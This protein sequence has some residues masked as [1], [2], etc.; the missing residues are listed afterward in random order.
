MQK[1]QQLM[2][3]INKKINRGKAKQKMSYNRK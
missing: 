3:E 1:Q 2:E